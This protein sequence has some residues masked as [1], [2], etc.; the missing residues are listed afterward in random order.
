VRKHL[1]ESLIN[2]RGFGLTSQAV[3]ELCLD[4]TE[5]P[6]DVRP[7]VVLLEEPFL[8]VGIIVEHPTPESAFAFPITPLVL[9][10]SL[11]HCVLRRAIHLERNVGHGVVV[12]YRL[13]I[14]SRE[15]RLVCG[16]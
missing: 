5:R 16:D 14:V 3:T 13:Q 1:T 7:L 4:H 9:V 11:C 15:I 6:L 12:Y 8:I 2:L 10:R